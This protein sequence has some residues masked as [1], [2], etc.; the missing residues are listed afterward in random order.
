MDIFTIN[1]V[2]EFKLDSSQCLK[3]LKHLYGLCEIGDLWYET[4][5]RHQRDDLGTKPLQS[6][7]VL[8]TFIEHGILKGLSLGFVNDLIRAGD[9]D[10]KLTSEKSKRK[11]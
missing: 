11:V 5:A 7:P 10:S 6:E 4:L 3:L 1:P 9:K 2:P 8:Y